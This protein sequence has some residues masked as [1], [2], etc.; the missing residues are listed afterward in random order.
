MRSFTREAAQK[1]YR[2]GVVGHSPV[3]FN[4]QEA[5]KL[6]ES[7][8]VQAVKQAPKDHKISIVS[9]LT[10]FGI[11]AVA[12]K[13]AEEKGYHTVGYACSQ[14]EDFACFPVDK[15]HIIGDN[16]GDESE[17]FLSNIDVLIRIG[18]GK[19]SKE[20]IKKAKELDLPVYEEELLEMVSYCLMG[21]IDKNSSQ[22]L[23]DAVQK[24]DAREIKEQDTYH[25]TIRFWLID[26]KDSKHIKNVKKYLEERFKHPVL[27]DI[28]FE[29]DTDVFG[30]EEAFVLHVTSPVLTNLQLELDEK[31][32]E[33][34]APP[35]D[36]PDYRPHI[37]VAEG[38]KGKP[39]FKPCRL[40]INRWFLTKG[41][42]VHE[43]S[44]LLWETEF[45]MKKTASKIVT[46]ERDFTEALQRARSVDEV[47]DFL[48]Y[49]TPE[50]TTKA[51][52]FDHLLLMFF[53]GLPDFDGRNDFDE[54]E[55]ELFKDLF[56]YEEF[57]LDRKEMTN[58]LKN[59]RSINRIIDEIVD[60]MPD[61]TKTELAREHLQKFWF[62]E[63]YDSDLNKFVTALKPSY[64]LREDQR[65]LFQTVTALNYKALQLLETQCI[66]GI[67]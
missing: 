54:T 29:G 42:N 46:S 26:P 55:V 15:K 59:Y 62:E 61:E 53:A 30:D 17:E 6:L 57:G 43:D 4:R 13:V 56:P 5:Q 50:Q 14:A 32:Q 1:Y 65:S 38:L 58:K 64:W 3:Y 19:Q 18:G 40:L 31:L 49:N 48:V 20:E 45:P 22:E 8:I 63:K 7:Q 10:N 16:W 9:G 11:P 41:T 36:Y 44:E 51:S 12:Y 25:V 67:E 33:L 66:K 21:S 23:F 2:I 37:T 27:V 24:Y 39:K 47:L 60:E 52:A 28:E 35:S 34:G